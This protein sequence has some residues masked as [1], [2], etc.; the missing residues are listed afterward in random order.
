MDVVEA[1]VDLVD[2]RGGYVRGRRV[3]ISGSHATR[4]CLDGYRRCLFE[5]Y[6][7][8]RSATFVRQH[9][10]QSTHRRALVTPEYAFDGSFRCCVYHGSCVHSVRECGL[11]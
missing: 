4:E 2:V 7:D 5:E 11:L 8:Y 6:G 3:R 10:E 1:H 9:I